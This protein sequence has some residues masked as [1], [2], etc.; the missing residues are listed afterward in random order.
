MVNLNLLYFKRFILFTL[1]LSPLFGEILPFFNPLLDTNSNMYVKLQVFNANDAISFDEFDKDWQRGYN[2]KNGSNKAIESRRYDIGIT[3]KY[4]YYIGFF[5]NHYSIL[6]A[7]RELLDFIHDIKTKQKYSK[8]KEY[9]AN[10]EIDGVSQQGLML[11]KKFEFDNKDYSFKFGISSYIFYANDGQ[12]GSLD[13][14]AQIEINQDYNVNASSNYYYKN[15]KLYD[16]HPNVSDGFGYGFNFA[17]QYTSKKYDF[18]ITTIGNNLFSN[19][20]WNSIAFSQ[21]NVET[22]NKFIDKDGY[23]KYNP[24]FFGLETYK[25]ILIK[26][27]PYYHLDIKKRFKYI[28]IS[29]GLENVEQ[30]YIP[31]IEIQKS[32]VFKNKDKLTLI[33]ENRF[34]SFGIKYKLNN[35]AFSI[36][37]NNLNQY[38]SL[39]MGI[40]YNF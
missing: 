3:N 20:Y 31:Y 28:N 12:K 27:L 39:G 37:A 17:L 22:K 26:T 5:F 38:S 13:A 36:I 2:P 9:N 7:N 18:T 6:T 40:E 15:N 30:I 34:K 33:Y 4:N 8:I 21:V 25:S 14:K 1:I 29:I 19:F 16:Y 32:N 24:T 23:A 35:F 11:S 10:L